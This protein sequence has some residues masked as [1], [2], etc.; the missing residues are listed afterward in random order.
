ME[1]KL[2]REACIWEGKKLVSKGIPWVLISLGDEGALWIEEK[3]SFWVHGLK[4]PVKSTVGAGDAMVA[5]CVFGINRG[6]S[7]EKI[8]RFAVAVS[9]GTIMEEGT[10]VAEKENIDLLEKKTRITYEL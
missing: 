1:K 9:S 8:A 3:K 4:V 6:W 2:T 5:A 10:Q 7:S